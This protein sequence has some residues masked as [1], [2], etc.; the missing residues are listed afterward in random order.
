[1]YNTAFIQH[2][3]DLFG[4][5]PDQGTGKAAC[6][7]AVRFDLLRRCAAR[8]MPE[9]IFKPLRQLWHAD[10][11]MRRMFALFPEERKG[12]NNDRKWNLAQ[13]LRLVAGVPG[14]TAECGVYRGASSYVM[15]R[16][17]SG[18]TGVGAPE[19]HHHIFDSFEGLS[20][21]SEF[22]GTHWQTSDLAAGEEVVRTLL[23]EFEGRFS[24][25]RGWI[26]G[27]FAEVAGKSFAFV[28]IDVDLYEPT[29]DSLEFFYAKMHP[30]G[31]ILCDDYGMISC[32]GATR[33]FDDFLADKPEKMLRL[34][35][36]GGFFRKGCAT[37]EKCWIFTQNVPAVTPEAAP[38]FTRIRAF[39]GKYLPP[40]PSSLLE[41]FT[42]LVECRDMLCPEYDLKWPQTDWWDSGFLAEFKAGFP[43][44]M[45]RLEADYYWG[46]SEFCRLAPEGSP[47]VFCGAAAALAP[48]LFLV[49]SNAGQEPPACFYS[50]GGTLDLADRASAIHEISCLWLH[51]AS[52]EQVLEALSFFYP[53]LKPGAACVCGDDAPGNNLP[54]AICSF[55]A[56]KKEQPLL[57]ASGGVVFFKGIPT[58]PQSFRHAD[59]LGETNEDEDIPRREEDSVQAAPGRVED[60]GESGR[61]WA[62][63]VLAEKLLAE[64]GDLK[65][66][67]AHL[68]RTAGADRMASSPFRPGVSFPVAGRFTPDELETLAQ[69]APVSRLLVKT[70]R[71]LTR[72][73]G[74]SALCRFSGRSRNYASRLRTLTRPGKLERYK[75][76]LRSPYLLEEI[77]GREPNPPFPDMDAFP[78]AHAPS[79]GAAD[80]SLNIV[81]ITPSLY[82]GGA[83]R[84]IASLAAA[85]HGRGHR[86]RFFASYTSG[87]LGHYE[88]ILSNAGVPVTSLEFLD[89][90]TLARSLSEYGVSSD[91]LRR[92]PSPVLRDVL[93]VTGALLREPADSIHA[94]LD[95]TNIIAGWAGLLTGTPV[96]RM[97][98]RNVNPTNFGFYEPWM[99]DQ[100]KFLLQNPRISAEANARSSARDY[101]AWLGIDPESVECIPNG[102]SPAWLDQASGEDAAALR[103]EFGISRDAPVVLCIC[104]LDPE[105]RPLDILAVFRSVAEM[106]PA[107]HCIHVGLGWMEAELHAELKKIPAG[108]AERIHFAG[109]R[110]DIPG[111][112][113]AANV[114]LLCSRVEGMPNVIMEAMM[115]GLP[116]VAT[117]VGGSPDLV[118]EGGTG[119]LLE[120]EDTRGLA[121]ATASLLDDAGLA[122]AMGL[123]AK[124]RI[125]EF[126]LQA[127]AGRVE[128][129]YRTR[130]RAGFS[131]PPP[132]KLGV[133][134][135]IA[136]YRENYARFT[137]WKSPPPPQPVPAAAGAVEAGETERLRALAQEALLTLEDQELYAGYCFAP[138]RSVLAFADFDCSPAGIFRAAYMKQ[139][140]AD[141]TVVLPS[142]PV[143]RDD[144]HTPLLSEVLARRPDL[145]VLRAMLENKSFEPALT[146]KTGW[147]ETLE[148]SGENAFDFV[149]SIAEFHQYPDP[150]ALCRALFK[151][152]APLCRHMHQIDLSNREDP[153]RPFDHLLLPSSGAGAGSV[154][155]VQFR[156]VEILAAF[157]QAGFHISGAETNSSVT[158][159]YFAGFLQRL[160]ASS[161]PYR[162][163]PEAYLRPTS[164]F[165]QC[166]A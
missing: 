146:L 40:A 36:G 35:D 74:F 159:D 152:S 16:C 19:R 3:L 117:R 55:F 85:M 64:N 149:Y 147:I 80:G 111:F 106:N 100:Y 61:Y 50:E 151:A 42:W 140:G 22:D 157:E 135:K 136:F 75:N 156:A 143:W 96:I 125:R 145:A 144:L 41:R 128:N 90:K 45:E 44:T 56:D 92:V 86:V 102:I 163:V 46:M 99:Y 113:S 158:E 62:K 1:M 98:W 54:L 109:A 67:L 165:L 59:C 9:Y 58:I 93:A 39:S 49:G 13:L 95:H 161:S 4:E 133:V 27:R 101:A 18:E 76:I 129:A 63:A 137:G 32:P 11:A 120:P 15:L 138:P 7:P 162:A 82:P 25:Y 83:E 12:M 155:S 14:D 57:M 116:V 91:A 24:L 104:R 37:K 88:S 53:R 70:L 127:L 65:N 34:T 43:K 17:L 131:A 150:Y 20:C 122:R 154:Q 107:A 126:S 108:I 118:V 97:S 29:R 148:A 123:A 28:H 105:K 48:A 121:A 164:L 81:Y 79:Q 139:K 47:V 153:N 103:G 134:G 73:P 119:Y 84:Q 10:P 21:P 115:F 78:P 38:V 77:R 26:P 114:L 124:E 33:A 51:C 132:A 30:G 6:P 166:V 2:L 160:R 72:T 31:I 68:C 69:Y 52:T 8:I 23:R 130:L 5:T 141:V 94:Y 110:R 142:I 71:T 112:L 66:R 87:N 89:E 60:T